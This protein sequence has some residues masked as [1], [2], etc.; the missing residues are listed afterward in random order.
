MDPVPTSTQTANDSEPFATSS[1]P[2][3]VE[4][5]N[6]NHHRLRPLLRRQDSTRVRSNVT[7]D[8][9]SLSRSSKIILFLTI[10]SAITQIAASSVALGLEFN[11]ECDAPL[12][13]F[14]IVTI[15]RLSFSLPIAIYQ[16]THPIQ[17]EEF[18]APPSACTTLVERFRQA[19]EL[20]GTIWFLIGNY[21]IYTSYTCI[22]TAPLLFKVSLA[23][24]ILGYVLL[25][26]PLF[27]CGAMICCLPCVLFAMR[28][29]KEAE[30]NAESDKV[31]KAIPAERF[32]TGDIAEEDAVCVI[33]LSSYEENEK[34]KKL[35]CKHHF[36]ADC[37][38]EWIRVNRS[39]PLCMRK[40]GENQSNA[41]SAA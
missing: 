10:V 15:V 6:E 9:Q 23:W 19:I 33:C 29:F 5:H 26:I 28:A 25:A 32:H 39:C 11:N 20:F 12:Q 21:W 38:D 16:K 27:V 3:A 40:L 13:I 30:N 17:T 31:I 7:R 2:V 18:A 1:E 22:D 36:H 24:I 34:L 4:S 41:D 14:L 8:I 37:I 35:P